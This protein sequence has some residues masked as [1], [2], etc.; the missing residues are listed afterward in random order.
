MNADKLTA[1]T[2]RPSSGRD[3]GSNID[4]VLVATA[5][6]VVLRAGALQRKHFGHD[7][8][9]DKKGSIDLVTQV[10]VE[11]ETM[12]RKMIGEHC[13]GTCEGCCNL[14]CAGSAPL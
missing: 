3:D 8:R 2:A 11:V 9:V 7:V 5:A 6:E 14:C 13:T 1:L 10:D 4:P 12:F